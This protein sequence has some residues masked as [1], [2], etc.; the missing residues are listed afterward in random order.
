MNVEIVSQLM[1]SFLSFC[2]NEGKSWWNEAQWEMS[3]TPASG[4]EKVGGGGMPGNG[5][6]AWERNWR[7]RFPPAES[8]PMM[9][10]EGETPLARRW[11][12]AAVA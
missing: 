11:F 1:L 5:W 4:E 12:T 3:S 2:L 7:A 10:L 6:R 8:P 9:R